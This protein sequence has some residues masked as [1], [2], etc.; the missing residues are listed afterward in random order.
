MTT[1]NP[2]IDCKL[3]TLALSSGVR[4]AL[5]QLM[6]T[7]DPATGRAPQLV[8][9]GP[10]GKLLR[11]ATKALG[12]DE[13]T[14]ASDADDY[15]RVSVKAISAGPLLFE[16]KGDVIGFLAE[17]L[18]PLKRDAK[19]ERKLGEFFDVLTSIAAGDEYT[20]PE[21]VQYSA[22]GEIARWTFVPETALKA[23]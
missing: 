18:M 4:F 11:R 21:G 1:A 10:S 19:T 3:F 5:V 15:A 22:E 16:V 23:A 14:A 2:T 6:N 8:A 12:I 9:D 17:K 13:I 20:A 7:A